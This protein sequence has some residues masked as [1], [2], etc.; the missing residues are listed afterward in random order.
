MKRFLSFALVLIIML[1]LNGCMPHS[2][3]PTEVGVR[4]IKFSLFGNKGVQPDVYPPGSTYFFLPFVNDWHTFDT[5]LQIAEMAFHGDRSNHGVR[6][7]LLFKTID[8]NDISLDVIVSYRIDPTKAPMILREV[9]QDDE[10]LK[11]NIVR[12]VARSKPR[13]IFGELNTEQFY[14]AAERTAKEEQAAAVMNEILQPYGVIVERVHTRDYR[15][16]EAY[17]QAIEQ[18]KVADQ[19]AE[20]LKSQTKAVKEEFL[21]KVEEAKGEIAKIKAEADGEFARA[22]IEADAYYEQQQ[23]VAEAIQAEGRAEAEGI[24]KMNEA[25]AG[26]GGAAMV[27]LDI[28][29]ALK[30]KKIVLLPIGG[31]GLD[32]RSTDVNA[33]LQLYGIQ[34][35]TQPTPKEPARVTE[36][37][38][39]QNVQHE[40][41]QPQKRR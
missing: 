7:D 36:P 40:Q 17:Q 14:I 8:G 24:R 1:A 25:L 16:S 22:V 31:G 38:S 21:M 9:A 26:A 39:Q 11:D 35:L 6:D 34:K 5:K 15:F 3:G 37:A 2:T 19:M 33:L 29:N 23:K 18:K 32:V 41:K 27:K 12:T 13:D 30:N 20:K 4:T 10:I 28:A